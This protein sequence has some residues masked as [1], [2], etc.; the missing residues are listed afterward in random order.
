M[1]KIT[2]IK[3]YTGIFT[4]NSKFFIKLQQ[5]M[6]HFANFVKSPRIYNL[7]FKLNNVNNM[8]VSSIALFRIN[9]LFQFKISFIPYLPNVTF[10]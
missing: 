1:C 10:F 2:M 6:C 5:I 9:L 3:W 7:E 4:I 8:I